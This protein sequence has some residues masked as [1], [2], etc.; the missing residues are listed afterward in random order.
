MPGIRQRHSAPG[1]PLPTPDPS[2]RP[3]VGIELAVI[4]AVNQP[5]EPELKAQ[6]NTGAMRIE[7]HV[8]K[9]Y[10]VR[11]LITVWNAPSHQVQGLSTAVVHQN[12]PLAEPDLD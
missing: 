2:I 9:T 5:A 1:G 10:A 7:G 3:L 4:I 8:A 12:A 6:F 11:M